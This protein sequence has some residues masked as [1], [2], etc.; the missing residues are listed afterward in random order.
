MDIFP[1]ELE[2]RIGQHTMPTLEKPLYDYTNDQI[3]EREL[4]LLRE[5]L[6]PNQVK[7]LC[8]SVT[9]ELA[10]ICFV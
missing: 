6:C 8:N 4:P 7:V 9:V 10:H 1:S 2:S 5:M 3:V